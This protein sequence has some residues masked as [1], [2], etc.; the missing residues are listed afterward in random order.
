[1]NICKAFFI[2]ISVVILLSGIN[3]LSNTSKILVEL[4]MKLS[5]FCNSSI[6]RALAKNHDKTA[7]IL[8]IQ[9]I[10]SGTLL[11]II[12][13]NFNNPEFSRGSTGLIILMV[14]SVFNII[15]L[16]VIVPSIK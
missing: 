6:R 7:K 16:T 5:A 1:M 14:I 11:L 8:A 12:S 13:I 15:I 10:I 9:D 2:I 4:S 3:S